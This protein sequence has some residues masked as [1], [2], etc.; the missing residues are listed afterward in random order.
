MSETKFDQKFYKCSVRKDG[1]NF[2]IKKW[3][4]FSNRKWRQFSNETMAPIFK[5]KNGANF[6]TKK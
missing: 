3:R 1:A 6:Q 2:Q 5:R 4:Q